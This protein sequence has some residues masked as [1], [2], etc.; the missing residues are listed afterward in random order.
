MLTAPLLFREPLVTRE[1]ATLGYDF[2]LYSETGERA[3]MGGIAALLGSA[4]NAHGS[5]FERLQGRLVFADCGQVEV[6]RSPAPV[7]RLVLEL[8]GEDALDDLP[9]TI[10]GWKGAGFGLCLEVQDAEQWPA[11]VLAEATHLRIGGQ[12]AELGGRLRAL[13]GKKIAAVRDHAGFQRALG[14]G[15]DL[16]QGYFFTEPASSGGAVDAS[17]TNIV[18]LMK[19][20]QEDAPLAKLEGLLK[21]D[22]ALSFKLLRYINSAGFG[23]SCEIQSFR[24]AVTVLGYKN[25]HKWLALLLV[26]AAR[27]NSGAALVTTAIAR[28]RLA[29]LL[30]QDLF[31]PQERDNL[32]ITGTFSLLH[33]ILQMPLEKITEQVALPDSVT[34]ALSDRSGP[35]G[36]LLELI[37]ATETL[38]A[39]GTPQRVAELAM[40]LGLTHE[41]LNRAQVE[42][43]AWAEGLTS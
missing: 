28:G 27:H 14:A 18:N 40:S 10:K 38:D 39:P 32:F 20:A 9:G 1:R 24:H 37:L 17:Y 12:A 43:I 13:P 36:P 25:L 33:A 42:A 11:T 6:E 15:F 26:T 21:R 7:G 2:T 31:D 5:V 30:G 23:L 16:C 4:S 3:P 41:A 34:A 22:A 29:E 35:F 8:K 19:L